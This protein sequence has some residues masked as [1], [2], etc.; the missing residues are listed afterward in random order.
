MLHVFGYYHILVRGSGNLRTNG[1]GC[2]LKNWDSGMG[3][4]E[5]VLRYCLL[6]SPAVMALL[7]LEFFFQT[8]LIRHFPIFPF[9]YFEIYFHLRIISAPWRRVCLPLR[10]VQRALCIIVSAL[11][12][13]TLVGT[14]GVQSKTS[15]LFLGSLWEAFCC[16]WQG[17]PCSS[18]SWR[19]RLTLNKPAV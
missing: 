15:F 4:A 16:C 11:H 6:V 3:I 5:G 1:N 9:P 17:G 8:V 13:H 12:D 10:F 2:M 7:L 14:L 18:H 19:W